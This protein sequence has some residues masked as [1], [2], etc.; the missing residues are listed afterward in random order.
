M[1]SKVMTELKVVVKAGTNDDEFKSPEEL[2]QWLRKKIVEFEMR[3]NSDTTV[4]VHI[5]EGG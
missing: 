4:R 5:E 1:N 2:E 3:L